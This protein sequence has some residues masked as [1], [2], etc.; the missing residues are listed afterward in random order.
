MA[1][2]QIGNEVGF[3]PSAFELFPNFVS[4]YSF[5]VIIAMVRVFECLSL[6]NMPLL[7][8][9][10]TV[11]TYQ[12]YMVIRYRAVVSSRVVTLQLSLLVCVFPDL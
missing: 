4:Y 10:D 1:K 3:F 7:Y 2:C 11:N 8:K 6:S 12:I 9:S 5:K